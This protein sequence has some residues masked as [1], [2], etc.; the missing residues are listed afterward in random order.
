MDTLEMPERSKRGSRLFFWAMLTAV[1]TAIVLT[2]L[3]ANDMRGLRLIIQRYQITWITLA[4][5]APVVHALTAK[6]GKRLPLSRPLDRAQITSNM[7]ND[8]HV[9]ANATVRRWQVSGEDLCLKLSEV[10]LNVTS[11]HE[12][13]LYSSTYECS[14]QTDDM[15]TSSP[16]ASIFLLVRG[17][18]SGE[19]SSVRMKAILPESDEGKIAEEK[20]QALVRI[21]ISQTRWS[22]FADFLPQIR[23]LENVKQS[24]YGARLSFSHEFTDARR[25][26]FILDLHPDTP[27]QRLT[28][29]YF[30]RAKWLVSSP[31]DIDR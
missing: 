31:S 4:P 23:S 15:Q 9:A 29:I 22:E 25:F 3:L 1:T 28:A 21:L 18:A 26:N 2:T 24:I 13:D 12:G 10:G 6:R 20:F 30:D 27:Q 7:F 5:P 19:V 11:W 17:N 8:L 16:L 14:S